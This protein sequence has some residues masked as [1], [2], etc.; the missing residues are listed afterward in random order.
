MSLSKSDTDDAILTSA[1]RA[2]SPPN[3]YIRI[4]NT[5]ATH[6]LGCYCDLCKQLKFK[7]PSAN[8]EHQVKQNL[9]WYDGI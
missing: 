1:K 5:T 7:N 3:S 8:L 9:N 4:R 6:P 2:D